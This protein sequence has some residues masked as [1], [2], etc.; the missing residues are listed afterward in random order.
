MREREEEEGEQTGGNVIKLCDYGKEG[1]GKTT[2]TLW[3]MKEG[4]L[5]MMQMIWLSRAKAPR[6]AKEK[7]NKAFHSGM[8]AQ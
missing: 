7:R 5:Q 4:K 1:C 3:I 6:Q 8:D 2:E